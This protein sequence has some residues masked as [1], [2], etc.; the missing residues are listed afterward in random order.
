MMVNHSQSLQALSGTVL[1]ISGI[2]RQA[3]QAIATLHVK[4]L[5]TVQQISVVYHHLLIHLSTMLRQRVLIHQQLLQEAHQQKIRLS[6]LLSSFSTEHGLRVVMKSVYQF[7]IQTAASQ[8]SGQQKYGF[9]QQ[10]VHVS[11]LTVILLRTV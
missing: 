3:R 6:T 9:Q 11:F 10:Q 5:V 7:L 1:L 4:L 8:D 2:H